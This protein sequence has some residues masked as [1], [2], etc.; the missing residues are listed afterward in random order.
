MAA[1]NAPV[2]TSE[3]VLR[4][5]SLAHLRLAPEEIARMTEELG[6]ILSY[7]KQL[8]ELSVDDVA[9]T[10]HVQIERL[11]LRADETKPSLSHDLAL[12]EAPR[13]SQDGFA[14]PSFVDE[15]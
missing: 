4:I 15:G 8:E 3:E 7:V 1:N 10:A 11:A 9:P 6:S 12:R 2:I 14:V 5:A 13:V